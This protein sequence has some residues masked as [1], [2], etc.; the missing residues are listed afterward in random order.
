MPLI[1]GIFQATDH[2]GSGAHEEFRQLPLGEA[3]F[4]TKVIDLPS[5]LGVG[6]LLLIGGYLVWVIADVAVIRILERVGSERLF[7]CHTKAPVEN[8]SASGSW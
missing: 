8:C 2:R 7:S 6:E 4:G 1:I 3:D 5:E